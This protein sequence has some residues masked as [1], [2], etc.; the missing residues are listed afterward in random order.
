MRPPN[1]SVL[2]LTP[3]K[4]EAV[5]YLRAWGLMPCFANEAKSWTHR[6][7]SPKAGAGREEEEGWARAPKDRGQKSALS[8]PCH[9][10]GYGNRNQ[11]GF[12]ND[13]MER[14]SWE[15]VLNW[16][17]HSAGSAPTSIRIL[18]GGRRF[19]VCS[20]VHYV[21]FCSICSGASQARRP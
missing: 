10:G 1:C 12:G 8:R 3:A 6:R 4:R 20:S 17:S 21:P 16:G 18:G 2:V 15:R 13:L 19:D 7:L 11:P 5:F 14:L 9:D